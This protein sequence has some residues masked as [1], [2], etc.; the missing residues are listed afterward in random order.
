MH[1]LYFQIRWIFNEFD[2]NMLCYLIQVIISKKLIL[3]LMIM[4]YS[5]NNFELKTD[6]LINFQINV[7]IQMSLSYDL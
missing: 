6:C 5:E 1:T 4:H 7:S 3:L 2:S